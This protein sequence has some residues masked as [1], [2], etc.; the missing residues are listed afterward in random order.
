MKK[1]LLVIL[2][3]PICGLTMDLLAQSKALNKARN[4]EFKK[5]TKEWKQAG[6]KAL[7]SSRSQDVLLLQH[8]ERLDEEGNQELTII[9]ENCPTINLCAQKSLIDAQTRYATLASNFIKGRINT[10][11]G[12]DAAN[13]E[14]TAAVRDRFYAAYEGLVKKNVSRVL[15]KSL[16]VG[17]KDGSGYYYEAYYLINED[18]ARTARQKA[19]DEA[20]KS[21]EE[22]EQN[23]KWGE[24]IGDFI[25]DG[26]DT[27]G[28]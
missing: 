9:T 16:V 17:K 12:L 6:V 3:I 4:K 24:S 18:K 14:N 22:T 25:K 8:Y 26:F 1:L 27:S 7:E 28:G 5:K 15:T 19:L 20:K 21:L 10:E 2:I 11:G 13:P 23:I